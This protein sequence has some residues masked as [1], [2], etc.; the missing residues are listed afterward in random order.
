MKPTRTLAATLIMSIL[1][2]VLSGCQKQGPAEKAGES[3]DE[4]TETLGENI[5]DAGDAIQ[6]AVEG[7]K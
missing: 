7:D 6:D 2:V 1:L 4:A 5:E 3:I